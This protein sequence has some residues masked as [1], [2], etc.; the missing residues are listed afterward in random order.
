MK[1]KIYY[2]KETCNFVVVDNLDVAEVM[3]GGTEKVMQYINAAIPEQIQTS[4][5]ITRVDRIE[6]VKGDESR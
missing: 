3:R 2:R 5:G 4:E 6:P 1:A